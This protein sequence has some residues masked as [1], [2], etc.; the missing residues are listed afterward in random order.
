[1]KELTQALKLELENCQTFSGSLAEYLNASLNSETDKEKLCQGWEYLQHNITPELRECLN[2]L[3]YWK[4]EYNAAMEEYI[5]NRCPSPLNEQQCK[6]LGAFVYCWNRKAGECKK[7]EIEAAIIA[8]GYRK[9][10]GQEKELD[11]HKVSG[12]F[13]IPKIGI[14]GSFESLEKTEG[15]LVYVE[16]IR[17]LM[18]IPKGNKT[19]G[20]ALRECAYIMEA[21][22]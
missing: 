22:L 12:F 13:N 9:I 18:L 10:T 8:Q 15:R 2:K 5:L 4:C 3:E 19:R 21:T 17:S 6:Q 7:T 20:Y 1:M 11:G 16:R 14:L